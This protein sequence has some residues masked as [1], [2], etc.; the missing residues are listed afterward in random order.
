MARTV[1]AITFFSFFWLIAKLFIYLFVWVVSK[2]Y[3]AATSID[4]QIKIDANKF[5]ICGAHIIW[6]LIG[7]L[8]RTTP[9][10]QH[11]DDGDGDDDND[12]SV[13]Q[14]YH[15]GS[16]TLYLLIRFDSNTITKHSSAHVYLLRIL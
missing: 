7:I 15:I 4:Q 2:K 16:V 10:I 5:W 11:D 14:E 8:R 12:G 13:K 1:V 9:N 6:S 3:R